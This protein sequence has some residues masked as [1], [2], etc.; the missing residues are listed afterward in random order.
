MANFAKF[1]RYTNFSL[2]T[3][4][5]LDGG[6]SLQR[7]AQQIGSSINVAT[8]KHRLIC[9]YMHNVKLQFRARCAVAVQC[10]CSAVC[11]GG[12]GGNVQ[13]QS[14]CSSSGWALLACGCAAAAEVSRVTVGGET[15]A[16]THSSRPN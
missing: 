4:V 16:E 13:L 3:E 2:Y 14:R 8:L 1:S 6:I 5:Q 12:A 11:S 7:I 15:P 10:L 9:I